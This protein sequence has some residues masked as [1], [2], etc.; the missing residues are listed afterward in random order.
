MIPIDLCT[1]DEIK[2]QKSNLIKTL[3][4]YYIYFNTI[5]T[6]IDS[7]KTKFRLKQENVRFLLLESIYENKNEIESA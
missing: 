4:C 7:L 2:K 5:Q 6:V 1:Q 3:V